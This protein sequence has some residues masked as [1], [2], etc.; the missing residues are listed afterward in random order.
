MVRRL[1]ERG[2]NCEDESK[3]EK[4]LLVGEWGRRIVAEE[5]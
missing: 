1:I 4:G 2:I 5:W 3:E